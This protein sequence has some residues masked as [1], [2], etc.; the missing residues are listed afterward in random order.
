M[1]NI[2]MGPNARSYMAGRFVPGPQVIHVKI[3]SR[4][5]G[6]TFCTRAIGGPHE[7]AQL[8]NLAKRPIDIFALI[9]SR[10]CWWHEMGAGGDLWSRIE[11]P[12]LLEIEQ[13]LL[14]CNYPKLERVVKR[15]QRAKNISAGTGRI[16]RPRPTLR[17]DTHPNGTWAGRSHGTLVCGRV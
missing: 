12:A 10:F 15:Q 5:H 17:S 4:V 3:S 1:P 14:E 6:Q 9:Q 13:Y 2:Q 11:A 16:G 7:A 8:G